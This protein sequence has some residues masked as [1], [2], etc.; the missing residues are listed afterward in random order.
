[1]KL[2]GILGGTFNPI[3]LGHVHVAEQVLTQVPLAECRF[4]PCNQPVHRSAP[5]V[6]VQDRLQMLQL[7]LADQT[8][9]SVDT[10]EL[11][12]GGPSYMIDT[13]RALRADQPLDHFILIIGADSFASLNTWKDWQHL[14]DHCHL[15]VVNRPGQQPLSQEMADFA[16]NHQTSEVEALCVKPAGKIY[17][18]GIPPSPIS[19]TALRARLQQGED[20]ADLLHPSVWQY[21]KSHKL[22]QNL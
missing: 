17:F 4:L 19:A 1:M 2:I 20:V 10:H 8:Y 13:L 18:L 7:A 14:L 16:K 6:S 9:L 3:H 22:Y 15:L 5:T 21:I 12:R 11:D